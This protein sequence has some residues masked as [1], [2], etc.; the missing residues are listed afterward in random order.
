MAPGGLAVFVRFLENLFFD[1][2]VSEFVGVKYL[3]T[4]QT[5]NVLNIIFA[6]YHADLWVF[7]G[8]VHLEG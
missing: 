2:H 4:I 6:C 1:F 7:A 3:A 5:F 8:G